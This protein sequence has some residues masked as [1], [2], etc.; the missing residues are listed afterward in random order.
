[1]AVDTIGAGFWNSWPSDTGD[2]R[3]R[4][5]QRGHRPGRGLRAAAERG[6]SSPRSTRL[7]TA[8]SPELTQ[9]TLP[10]GKVYEQ[11]SYDPGTARLATYTDPD[12]GQWTISPPL[13]TGTKASSDALGYVVEDVS[14]TDPAGRHETYGYDVTDGGRLISYDNGVDPPQRVRLRRGR[15]PHHG[16]EPGRQPGLHDQRRPRQRADPDLVPGGAGDPAGH[17]APASARAVRRLDDVQPGLPG[18]RRGLHHV[19]QLLRLQRG[20]PARPD[21]RRADV[22]AGRPVGLGDRR[23]LRDDVRLQ[24]DRAA[25]AG[26]HAGRPAASRAAARPATR[27]R[28]GPRARPTAGRSRPG[29][30]CRRPRRA[31]RSPATPTT[32]TA[33]SRRPTEPSGRYTAYTYDGLGRAR[34]QPS[35]TTS[36]YPSGETTAYTYTP[37]GQRA[38]VTYPAVTNSV[39]N[40][41]HQLEYSYSYDDDNDVLTSVAVRRHRRGPVADHHAT[42]TTTTTRSPRSPSPPGRRPAAPRSPTGRPARTRTAR[43]PATTT[44]RSAT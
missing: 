18:Q 27:T 7:A 36:T 24:R 4:L 41:T 38:T 37:T 8:A 19:L 43:R 9:V 1:M 35:C 10:S 30:S 40:V 42:P 32:A 34:W 28:P 29:C 12:G 5:L 16:R 26:D 23:H 13:A 14:V 21:Q 6:R 11:A 22:G 31:A 33:T 3:A 15:V 2:R 39:T 20:Q 25:D 17:R 44:T